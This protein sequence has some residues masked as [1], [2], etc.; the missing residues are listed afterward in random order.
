MQ[1]LGR[2][3]TVAIEKTDGCQVYLS[4]KSL[5]TEIVSS[6]SSAMNVLIPN[7]NDDDFKEE[8]IPEQFKTV[9][10]ATSRKLCTTATE[11]A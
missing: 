11:T 1:V 4:R 10:N 7:E 5:D 3:P 9:F 2:V 8:P 6:K